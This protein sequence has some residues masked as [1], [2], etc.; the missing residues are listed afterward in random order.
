VKKVG[1]KHKRKWE[2]GG[3]VAVAT[4]SGRVL[5]LHDISLV[6]EHPV[7]SPAQPKHRNRATG[8]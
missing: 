6:W 3:K 4:V 2:K 1:G 8:M 7:S 5:V